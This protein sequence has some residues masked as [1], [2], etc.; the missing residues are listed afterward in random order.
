MINGLLKMYEIVSDNPRLLLV[1]ERFNISL[2]FG[3]Q[4]I[5]EICESYN[6]TER[7]FL[8]EWLR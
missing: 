4:T 8:A 7:L 5:H 6:I 3:D 1:L 2:G